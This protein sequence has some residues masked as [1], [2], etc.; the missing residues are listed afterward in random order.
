MDEKEKKQVIFIVLGVVL[1]A[2][3]AWYQFKSI[4]KPAPK[5]AA[6][7]AVKASG[8]QD[9]KNSASVEPVQSSL[10]VTDADDGKGK[11]KRPDKNRL[12]K[13]LEKQ[14]D[15]NKQGWKTDPF[16]P[17]YGK[18]EPLLPDTDNTSQVNVK[19]TDT[20]AIPGIEVLKLTAISSAG[21]KFFAMINRHLVKVNQSVEGYLVTDIQ[22]DRIILEKD[23]KKYDLC[24]GK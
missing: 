12:E 4:K 22:E 10:T 20:E 11:Y 21:G 24:L 5:P 17:E 15:L 23:G 19:E 6:V 3:I 13:M 14:A 18:K 16:F 8:G 1:M 2:G 7:P 9:Q